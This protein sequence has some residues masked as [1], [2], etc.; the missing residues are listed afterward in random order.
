MVLFADDEISGVAS[1]AV[2]QFPIRPPRVD[3]GKFVLLLVAGN[4]EFLLLVPILLHELE[5]PFTLKL[6]RVEVVV[7]YDPACG[8]A[9]KLSGL[10]GL[11]A[12]RV[13]LLAQVLV[14]D[15][16]DVLDVS[17]V[18]A[19]QFDVSGG[20]L[21]LVD[22][23]H[24]LPADRPGVD[25]GQTVRAVHLVPELAG[26][27][28]RALFV[29]DPVRGEHEQRLGP[30]L[31]EVALRITDIPD[32]AVGHAVPLAAV[33]E[34]REKRE[35]VVVV[36]RQLIKQ[37]QVAA[38]HADAGSHLHRVIEGRVL[39]VDQILVLLVV[40][41]EDDVVARAVGRLLVPDLEEL[42]PVGRAIPHLAELHPL[43]EPVIGSAHQGVDV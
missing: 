31:V 3:H 10:D 34:Y 43:P 24:P 9:L 26:V 41:A 35:V 27:V 33:A 17:G 16:C 38:P 7:E 32:D 1:H 37:E 42:H 28:E 6:E 40:L 19:G 14:G 23:M 13:G 18:V 12:G 39:S 22:D 2:E 11:A 30:A 21:L 25:F 36:G 29:D 20:Q 15:P 8:L 4:P 5:L